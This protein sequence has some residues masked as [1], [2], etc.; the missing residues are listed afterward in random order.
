VA[1]LYY[2]EEGYI[3]ISYHVYV[4]DAEIALG[5]YIEENYIDANYY[6]DYS[7][8][9]SL[10]CELTLRPGET[11]SATGAWTSAF[12]QTAAVGRL[13]SVSAD[14][15]SAF[16]PT[17]TV[18][19]F[20]NSFAV[21]DV[22]VAL[23]STAVATRSVNVLLEH[24]ADL[25]AMA[26]KTVD[27]L[28]PI[29]ATASISATPSKFLVSSATLTSTA[30]LSANV[31]NVTFFTAAFV[32]TTNIFTSRY[33]GSHRPTNIIE[34]TPVYDGSIKKFGTHSLSGSS[35]I[36]NNSPYTPSPSYR[37]QPPQVNQDWVVET[38]IYKSS[39][40]AGTSIGGN[41]WIQLGVS[42][43]NALFVTLNSSNYTQR[44]LINVVTGFTLTTNAWNHIAIV[45]NSSRI[46]VYRNGTRLGTTTT[47]PTSYFYHQPDTFGNAYFGFEA[48]TPTANRNRLDEFSIHVGTT[49]GYDPANSSISVPTEARVNDP[50]Y[51]R[52]LHHF[53][54]NGL[55]DILVAADATA[56]LSTTATFTVQANVSTK[57]GAAS[58]TSSA[59]VSV[60]GVKAVLANSALSSASSL[61][62]TIGLLKGIVSSQTAT[63]TVAAQA[64]RIKQ[65]DAAFGALF[66]P[67][68]SINVVLNPFAT[69]E[70]TTTVSVT[71]VKTTGIT[72]T[73]TATATQST[74][75]NKFAG[76]TKTL[77]VT[78]SVSAIAG[79]RKSAQAAIAAQATMATTGISPS[80][81]TAQLQS[82]FTVI[83]SGPRNIGRPLNITTLG[84][85][86]FGTGKYGQAYQVDS[87]AVGWTLPASNKYATAGILDF[88]LGIAPASG[89]NNVSSTVFEYGNKWTITVLYTAAP[90]NHYIYFNGVQ[91]GAAIGVFGG[92]FNWHQIRVTRSGNNYTISANGSTYTI[93][94][95]TTFSGTIRFKPVISVNQFAIDELLI[96]NENGITNGITTAP[97]SFADQTD[98]V[99]LWH[100][101]NNGFDDVSIKGT[102]AAAITATASITA[103]T[104][105]RFEARANVNSAVSINTQ[106]VKRVQGV[107]SI[108][109]TA[110]L[111]LAYSRIRSNAS[112]QQV[113]S[114]VTVN[115]TV[116]A[117]GGSAL[118]GVFSTVINASRIR[119]ATPQLESIATNLTAAF[120]NATGT[121][122]LE[123]QAT[124]TATV[125]KVTDQ[126][127]ALL[128]SATVDIDAQK[129][130]VNGSTASVVSSLAV[131]A[132]RIQPVA[133]A[134][135]V[136]AA[137]TASAIKRTGI[138]ANFTA[139]VTVSGTV[140]RIR[141]S[142]VTLASAVTVITNN[143]ILR[144]AQAQLSS[145]FTPLFTI[146]KL[147]KAQAA[148]SS[149]GFILTAGEVI[150]L[151]PY[152]TYVIPAET[153]LWQITAESRII[154]I[155][156][157]TRV[158]IV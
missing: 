145:Q 75:A 114:T 4:A 156:Q 119:F 121:V 18:D 55:D 1:D 6:D 99:G 129:L 19:A 113:V 94:N 33:F 131:E 100:F 106:A 12:T 84:G 47:L 41:V 142:A 101:D 117:S 118:T 108:S 58:L 3:D 34:G 93:T 83:A 115:P 51:T 20:K 85:G 11:V 38:W 92:G 95:A 79:F 77:S 13:Q 17:L 43:G 65:F 148:L 86:S 157:E 153:R 110:S 5:P 39:L 46:S 16:S 32:S 137:L 50:V 96:T 111:S 68:I 44:V 116:I 54:N 146:T 128:T 22:T 143:Q 48:S 123:S 150:N 14:F 28:S 67:S 112:F 125:R 24:I 107:A 57:Q 23:S 105:I 7:S 122:T 139:S 21:L 61:T 74:V 152:L 133:S 102:L 66:S 151:D 70:S 81:A 29:T 149:Q 71:A 56:A 126:P 64:Y 91:V 124:V 37:P 97:Y 158:N 88:W 42:S 73:L 141:R 10:T 26:A 9:A 140:S 53:D 80:L 109:S 89:Q 49:L 136:T 78:A 147:V 2:Y 155:E 40:T 60:T 63:A 36:R 8:V 35:E 104:T 90:N 62:A 69:L 72:K 103:S 25:N 52:L 138:V 127:I 87:G 82:Q 130:I 134:I 31:D 144:L 120:K 27:I 154:A 45:K 98:V 76:I 30:T 135:I 59:S 15:T 132:T